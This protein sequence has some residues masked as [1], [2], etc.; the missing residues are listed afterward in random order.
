MQ[1]PSIRLAAAGFALAAALTSAPL[2]SAQTVTGLT[3]LLQLDSNGITQSSL[4]VF[5]CCTIDSRLFEVRQATVF[6]DRSTLST[7][8]SNDFDGPAAAEA[9]LVSGRGTRAAF[10]ELNQALAE[11]RPFAGG[12]PCSFNFRQSLRPPRPDSLLS[13]VVSHDYRLTWFAGGNDVLTFTLDASRPLCPGPV[14]GL[15]YQALQYLDGVA[16][17]PA[18]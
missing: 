5:F 3:P 9:S 4:D 13:Q 1:K 6:T 12:A 10:A 8:T 14:R 15:V 11:A 16:R 2:A 7:F 17:Q 18:A